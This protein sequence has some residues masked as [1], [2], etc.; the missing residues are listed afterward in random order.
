MAVKV[1]IEY[2]NVFDFLEDYRAHI[3]QLRYTIPTPEPLATGQAVDIQ[4]TVPYG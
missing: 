3:S 2:D 1:P 4:F